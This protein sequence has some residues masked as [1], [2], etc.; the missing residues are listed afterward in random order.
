MYSSCK[1]VNIPLAAGMKLNCFISEKEM[2]S[3]IL[4]CA[5]V[6][7]FLFVFFVNFYMLI[8]Q[9]LERNVITFFSIQKPGLAKIMTFLKKS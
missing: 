3:S 9:L 5:L 1:I 6:L 2:L 4:R 7:L 8:N